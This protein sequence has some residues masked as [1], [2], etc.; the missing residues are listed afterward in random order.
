MNEDENIQ[1]AQEELK[2]VDHLIY[3]SLKYT[4]TC[5]IIKHV[6]ERIIA[7]FDFMFKY[8]LEDAK[9][10]NEIQTIPTAPA[11]QVEA[12]R[13]IHRDDEK[14]QENLDF[15][16]FLRKLSRTK[17]SRRQEYRRHVTMTSILNEGVVEV[18]IDV[19][20]E[21]FEKTKDFMEHIQEPEPDI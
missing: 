6:I 7:C 4:R 3:V 18:N 15:Y 17:F 2:R 21:Y 19:V 12:L 11:A 20:G 10:K 13:K 14:I 9:D 8:L 16:L 1:N 5:D